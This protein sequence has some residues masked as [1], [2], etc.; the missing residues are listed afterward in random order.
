MLS[1]FVV[2]KRHAG[3]QEA[4]LF[5]DRRKRTACIR[6][7]YGISGGMSSDYWIRQKKMAGRKEKQKAERK[8]N[9]LLPGI[10]FLSGCVLT[11]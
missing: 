8:K 2:I 9:G 3:R 10:F 7:L 11:I 6:R 5:E 1:N 4:G